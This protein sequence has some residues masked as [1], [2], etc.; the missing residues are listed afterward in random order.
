MK[1]EGSISETLVGM[2]PILGPSELI[3][4]TLEP[5]ERAGVGADWDMYFVVGLWVHSEHRGRGLGT[6]LAKEKEGLEWVRTNMDP[7]NDLEGKI[8]RM[9]LLLVGDDNASSNT[10]YR[11]V[12]FADLK[13]RPPEEENSH[14]NPT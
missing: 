10:L 4:V 13:S 2:R 9:V 14:M 11:K 1:V 5:F 3:P 12:C 8:S 6:H 7:K